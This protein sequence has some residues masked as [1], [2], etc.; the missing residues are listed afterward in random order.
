MVTS[1]FTLNAIGKPFTA[2]LLNLFRLLVLMCPLALL[3]K[4]M[5]GLFG[6]F[7]GMALSQALAGIIAYLSISPGSSSLRSN[8]ELHLKPRSLQACS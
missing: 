4:A 1:G 2:L 8:R 7:G 6:I 5:F 3:G